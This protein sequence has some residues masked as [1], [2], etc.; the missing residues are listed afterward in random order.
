[1]QQELSRDKTRILQNLSTARRNLQT[2]HSSIQ[3]L[4]NR[5][6]GNLASTPGIDKFSLKFSNF[7]LN[8]NFCRY[9]IIAA[10]VIFVVLYG[11][12]GLAWTILLYFLLSWLRRNRI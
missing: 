1:M 2:K 5:S 10:A 8:E 3:R 4:E 11:L 12:A 9:V 6:T 7:S